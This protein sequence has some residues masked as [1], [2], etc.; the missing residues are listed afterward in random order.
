MGIVSAIKSLFLRKPPVVEE[1]SVQREVISPVVTPVSKL[2]QLR[3]D[4]KAA[5]LLRR[6]QD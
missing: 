6:K 5:A 2:L 1:V 3:L 4:R